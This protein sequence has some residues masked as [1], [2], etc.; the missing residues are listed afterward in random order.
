MCSY[1]V[2]VCES[3]QLTQMRT[4]DFV[5]RVLT[6]KSS[7]NCDPGIGASNIMNDDCMDALYTNVLS[8]PRSSY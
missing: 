3:P 8:G 6:T 1:V 5:D 4:D 7:A 2:N